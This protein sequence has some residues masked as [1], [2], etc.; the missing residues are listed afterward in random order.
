VTWPE[1]EFHEVLRSKGFREKSVAVALS[2]LR[3]YL[4][5]LCTRGHVLRLNRFPPRGSLRGLG[6]VCVKRALYHSAHRNAPAVAR[7]HAELNRRGQ[8]AGMPRRLVCKVVNGNVVL[9]R[10]LW[11]LYPD[12]TFLA[13]VRHPYA[14]CEGQSWRGASQETPR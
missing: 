12:A 1:G 11:D 3:W 14:V 13:M 10:D 7:L 6:G 8:P 2:K 5:I 4:P 9:G